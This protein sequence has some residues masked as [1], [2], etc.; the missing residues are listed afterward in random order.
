MT[1]PLISIIVVNWNGQ[2]WLK[3]CLTS[4]Q[5]QTYPN[6]EIIVVDNGST[7]NSLGTIRVTFPKV[8][9]ILNETNQGFARANN[10]GVQNATGKCIVLLNNDSWIQPDCIDKLYAYYR[11]H[12][13]AVVAPIEAQYDTKQPDHYR[14]TIDPWGHPVYS[15]AILSTKQPFY[16]PGICLFFSRQLFIHTGG[17]DPL[18]FMYVEEVDWFWRLHLQN[19]TCHYVPGVYVFHA[20]A[21]S[22]GIGLTYTT[23]L[24]RNQNTL[25]MLIKNY[26]WYNLILIL[27]SYLLQNCFELLFF[28]VLLK[29]SLSYSYLQGW[30]FTASHLP[31]ILAERRDI[32][33]DRKMSDRV[34]FRLMYHGFGKLH[35]FS[36]YVR[37]RKA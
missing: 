17:F 34:I 26:A 5:Q 8:K 4:L 14:A 13:Y 23:F 25:T 1:Y 2:R 31:E 9:I 3:R 12:K 32:Q 35:H 36:R 29:P 21:G 27:P 10:L 37:A 24:W 18:F 7:D 15:K 19:K 22:T 33:A 16:L 20:G 30:W 11:T 6:V 28:L